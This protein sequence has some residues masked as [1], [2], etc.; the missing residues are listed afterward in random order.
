M[1]DVNN[2][3]PPHSH[4]AEQQLLGLILMDQTVLG[5]V[6]DFLLAE[7][8]VDP[9]HAA[10]FSEAKA[11]VEAGEI[12]NPVSLSTRMNGALSDLGGPPYLANLAAGAGAPKLAE[13][14]ARQILGLYLRRQAIGLAEEL[15]NDG[16]Q[17]S[18]VSAVLANA[19]ARIDELSKQCGLDGLRT[20]TDYSSAVREI[21]RG[22]RK[23][24]HSTGFPSLDQFYGIPEGEWTVVTG[25]PS[26]GKSQFLDAIL[27]NLAIRLG[28]Q[29]AMCSFE[30]SPDQHIARLA[31]LYLGVPFYAGRNSRM[32]EGDLSKAEEWINDHFVFIRALRDAPTID[33]AL[34]RARNAVQQRGIKGIVFDP[35]NEF[36]HLRDKGVS[37]TEYVASTLT[38]VRR[39]CE[40]NLVHLWFVAH[41]AKPPFQAQDEAPT[42]M[43][44][45]GSQH[46]VNKPDWGISIHRPWERDKRSRTAEIHVKKVRNDRGKFEPGMAKLEWSPIDR[47]YH[48]ISKDV[49]P[50]WS[51]KNDDET[52]C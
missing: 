45:S 31:E 36:E 34:A 30:T 14:Y 22:K 41:P 50:H 29:F 17:C 20:V 19:S 13:G 16:Y 5:K 48:E 10:I 49:R 21:Y 46:W 44:I 1:A 32:S 35:Y 11:C 15:A 37:E 12:A 38:K 25:W 2:H 47:R 9:G 26:A 27:V 7:H 6:G 24:A 40:S 23:Q 8:F 28:W 52:D 4:E 42:L 39:F 33:W 43:Q 18:D 3:I 51:D